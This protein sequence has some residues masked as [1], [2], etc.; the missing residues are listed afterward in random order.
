MEDVKDKLKNVEFIK[1]FSKITV[2]GACREEHVEKSNLYKLTASKESI[3][4][5]KDNIDRKIKFLYEDN[6]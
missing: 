2:I 5:I 3:Q 1:N 4:R 6:K